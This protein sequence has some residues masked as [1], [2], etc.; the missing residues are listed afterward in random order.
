MK[1]FYKKPREYDKI[2]D[3]TKYIKCDYSDFPPSNRTHIN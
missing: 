1:S 2:S 3:K